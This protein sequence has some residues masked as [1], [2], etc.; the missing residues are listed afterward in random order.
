MTLAPELAIEE[1]ILIRVVMPADLQKETL[2]TGHQGIR[3][4][5][6]LVAR[7]IH[8]VGADRARL[9]DTE[10]RT[11][12]TNPNSTMEESCHQL[13][14]MEKATYPGLIGLR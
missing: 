2:H 13:I 8:S 11:T 3:N 4:A 7:F 12:P 1:G 10:S 14:R 6:G 9:S 5:I